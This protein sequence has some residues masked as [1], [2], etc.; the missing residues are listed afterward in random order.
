MY[1]LLCPREQISLRLS[2]TK[3]A[4]QGKQS[5]MGLGSQHMQ[6]LSLHASFRHVA[7]GKA[8]KLLIGNGPIQSSSSREAIAKAL[9][10]ARSWY[11]LIVQGN[12][13][14]LPDICRLDRL[15]HRYVKNIFPLAFL[16]PESIKVFLNNPGTR[17]LDSLIGRV[18]TRWDE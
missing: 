12:V 3:G 10:R 17:T 14:G 18:P 5:V 13:S 15:S 16:S 9:A 6:T 8:L 7:Q 1:R 11:E 4:L 2:S